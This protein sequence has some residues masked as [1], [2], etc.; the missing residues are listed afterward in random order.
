MALVS[1]ASDV[2]P[3]FRAIDVAHMKP[4]GIK[5]DDYVYMSDPAN[6]YQNADD[7]QQALSPQ[8]GNPP[9]MPPTGPYWSAEQLAMFARW[10]SDGYQP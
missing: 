5:L 8:D 7:V 10:R 6:N 4:M 2:K 1:F 9:A 3:L